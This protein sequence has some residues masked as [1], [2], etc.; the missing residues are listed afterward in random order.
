MLRDA[1]E[2]VK[3]RNATAADRMIRR[4]ERSGERVNWT[5]TTHAEPCSNQCRSHTN[6]KSTRH[7]CGDIE[8]STGGSQKNRTLLAPRLWLFS[9][10][11]PAPP[12]RSRTTPPCE[13]HRG[14]KTKAEGLVEQEPQCPFL[15]LRRRGV[16]ITS[17]GPAPH[18][19][20]AP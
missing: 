3:C 14:R 17:A 1:L 5:H 15:F 10:P 8:R 20:A 16:G 2:K 7:I 4:T 19:C 6:P 13:L 9:Q 18:P 11:P 12:P